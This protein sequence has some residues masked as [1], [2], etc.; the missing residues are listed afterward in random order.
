MIG[1][2]FGSGS[3][4]TAAT[5]GGALLGAIAGNA[6]ARDACRDER[7]DAYYYQQTYYDAFDRPDYGRRYEWRNRYT[8]N[9]GYVTPR[10]AFRDS[11]GECREFTQEVY[12]DDYHSEVV[13][14][15]ACR[16]PDGRWRIVS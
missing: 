11:R 1:N 16:M 7:A 12:V 13:T 2:Q 10:R 5:I 14:G 4:R 3:G 9:Y 15:V 6:I 8:G